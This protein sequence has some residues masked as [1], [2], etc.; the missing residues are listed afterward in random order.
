MVARIARLNR[1][2]S[3]RRALLW[4]PKRTGLRLDSGFGQND[5]LLRT[6]VLQIRKHG[7]REEDGRRE[8]VGVTGYKRDAELL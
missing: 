7:L 4:P 3:R 5:L 8:V 2:V 6:L 1:V